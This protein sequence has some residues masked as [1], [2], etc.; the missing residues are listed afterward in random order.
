V[1]FGVAGGRVAIAEAWCCDKEATYMGG[2][3]LW[4]VLL[5]RYTSYAQHHQYYLLFGH[6]KLTISS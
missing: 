5:I 4:D 1:G 3:S 2:G 6:S